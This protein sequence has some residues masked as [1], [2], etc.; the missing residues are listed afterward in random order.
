MGRILHQE[1]AKKL[2]LL[3]STYTPY[4]KY[5]PE[6]ILENDEYKLYWDRTVLTDQPVRNNRPDLILINKLSRHTT[7]I[8][9]AVPNNNNLREKHNE[10]IAK[11]RDLEMQIKRQWNM[12]NVQTVP[13]VI[14]T[15]GVIPKTLIQNLKLLGLS[16]HLFKAMQKAVLLATARSVRKFLGDTPAFQV[17]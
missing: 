15:T 14:S 2:T 9:I 1:L 10:K 8:D 16:E 13:I 7:L 17:T 4:Y 11:Y 3:Q 6:T 12:K 5:N